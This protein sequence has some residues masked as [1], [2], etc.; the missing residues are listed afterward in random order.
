[1]LKPKSEKTPNMPVKASQKE[2][3]LCIELTTPRHIFTV[4]FANAYSKNGANIFNQTL[5]KSLSRSVLI[6]L[7]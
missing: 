1:V 4:F 7:S 6:K 3:K 2:L 5:F